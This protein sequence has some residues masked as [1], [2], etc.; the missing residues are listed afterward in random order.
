[1]NTF[2]EKHQVENTLMKYRM[3]IHINNQTLAGPERERIKKLKLS[4]PPI[5]ELILDELRKETCT[6]SSLKMV[7]TNCFS[8]YFNPVDLNEVELIANDLIYNIKTQVK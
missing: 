6:K 2:W 8:H 4:A 7:L 1:M 3:M 5:A